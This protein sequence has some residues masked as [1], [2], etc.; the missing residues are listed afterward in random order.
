M[1]SNEKIMESKKLNRFEEKKISVT[2][3]INDEKFNIFFLNKVQLVHL[4]L[5]PSFHISISSFMRSYTV[6]LRNCIQSYAY[7]LTQI[8][9]LKGYSVTLL[10]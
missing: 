4:S 5:S 2:I 9:E 6:I 10:N 1:E 8:K 3:P 7:L